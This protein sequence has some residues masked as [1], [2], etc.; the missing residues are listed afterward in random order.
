[1]R[2]VVF[3]ADNRLAADWGP[4]HAMGTGLGSGDSRGFVA[5]GAQVGVASMP[6]WLSE[7]ERGI[8][9]YD[10]LTARGMNLYRTW[11]HGHIEIQTHGPEFWVLTER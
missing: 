10:Q 2:I 5:L 1:M 6:R 4:P 9:V 8:R 11:E 7:D 3:D